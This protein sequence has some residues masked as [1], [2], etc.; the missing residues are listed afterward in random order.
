MIQV[1]GL[2][3]FTARGATQKREVFFQ[4]NWRFASI[5]DVFDSSKLLELL[6]EIPAPEHV[7]LYFTVA[8]CFEERGRKLQEQWVIP[9]D[10]DDIEIRSEETATQDA[11]RVVDAAALALG[12]PPT[13]IASVF[14]GNGV[15][16]FVRMDRPILSE[17]FFEV[18]R[19]HYGAI[20]Q[21]IQM[22][23]MEKGLKGKVD[24][25]V[26]SKGRLM[27]LPETLNR[28]PGKPERKARILNATLVPRSFEL[29]EVSGL[30]EFQSPEHVP[31]EA[32]KN[33]PKPDTKAI[34]EG[35][36]FLKHCRENQPVIPEYQWY[37]MQSVVARLDDGRELV[38][39]YSA[40]HPKY[41]HYETELKIDQA[42]TASG[43][44]T[45]RNI[46]SLWGGCKDCPFYDKV[47]SPIMI[48]GPDYVASKDFG[49]RERSM[50]KEGNVRPGRPVYTDLIKEFGH[51]HPFKTIIDNGTTY[52]FNGKF[53]LLIQEPELKAWVTA[54][55][56]P[57]PM[58][59][60][61]S[62]FMTQLGAYNVTPL[63]WFSS[64]RQRM[65]NFQ[66]AVLDLTTMEIHPH[67]PE[68]GFFNVL[69]FDYDPHA[70]A[71]RWEKFLLEIMAEDP[72]MVQLLKEFGGYAIS[73]DDYWLH[74]ALMLIGDGANG[75][76]VFMEVLGEVVGR[77]AHSAVPAQQMGNPVSRMAMHNKLFNY[78]EETSV[79]A[80]ES[81]EAFKTMSVGGAVEYKTLYIQPFT[82]KSRT[83]LIMSANNMPYSSDKSYGFYRR[84]IIV[85][86]DVR[87]SRK[88]EGYDPFIKDKLMQELP[89]ICN[90]LLK[91]YK[92]LV[93]RRYFA[94]EEKTDAHL[95]QYLLDSDNVA[96]FVQDQVEL[97][98][99]DE[100]Y[101]TNL[102][103]Y[104]QYVHYCEMNGEKPL[105]S[106]YFGR[107]WARLHPER[108]NVV[109]KI[110]GRSVR[111]I[112][113][114]QLQKEF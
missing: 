44:R 17:E 95:N 47:T 103:M 114:I 22:A 20:C 26:F 98:E 91:A 97:V 108:R 79:R 104:T 56:K 76:S 100:K 94:A 60:E 18:N 9:F 86:F 69:P 42:L 51:E 8:S 77:E 73:G 71:P 7:N 61:M 109:K 30:K 88:K 27:R 29:N 72:D 75:K 31:D 89:G 81:N 65:M 25:S 33:Y 10:V 53:W 92:D 110:E 2:R 28:K 39:E 38:H 32:L 83:K 99:D 59:H 4:K 112:K 46:D 74:K 82:A 43:P 55:V 15:Q 78:S 105:A 113:G 101:E 5:E 35:C 50:D 54:K 52:I 16:F 67:R 62:E 57:E 3:D 90:S 6:Q 19:P 23:L 21:R 68:F 36:L 12:V 111:V 58:G 96:R 102:E 13:E 34:L 80:L 66:N 87:F 24:P 63:E 41:N 1:L 107:Q 70:S 106:V 93:Q 49:F 48:K 64:S 14:T 40:L 85:P 84:L 37:A 11:R 45:C